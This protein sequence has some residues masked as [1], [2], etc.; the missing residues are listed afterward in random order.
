MELPL[1]SYCTAV[2][3]SR[4]AR[5][6]FVASQDG[7]VSTWDVA[8]GKRLRSADV[9]VGRI[10]AVSC[11]GRLAVGFLMRYDAHVWDL[12]RNESVLTLE[13]HNHYILCAAFSRD[14]RLVATGSF[15]CTIRVWDSA[16]GECLKVLR[17]HTEKI[18]RVKFS[19]DGKLLASTSGDYT[20]RVWDVESGSLMST[21][22]E[23]DD[24]VT[25]VCFSRN[26]RVAITGS[27][28]GTVQVWDV[29]T[30]EPKR[31]LFAHRNFVTDVAIA[32]DGRTAI[33]AASVGD[34]ANMWDLRTGRE[35][36]VLCE[37]E[38]HYVNALALSEDGNTLLTGTSGMFARVMDATPKWKKEVWSLLSTLRWDGEMARELSH[39][40]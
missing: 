15:D 12:K 16:T 28:D 33:S 17:G 34:A 13:G 24:A 40:F 35:L 18:T 29:R 14:A 6:A 2:T 27:D 1:T 9:H 22:D 5:R 11:D 23:H 39:F 32:P 26:S 31:L 36:C 3:L 20:A 4:D 19:F 8:E 10:V 30:G 38:S 21:F 25:S 37:E 7:V